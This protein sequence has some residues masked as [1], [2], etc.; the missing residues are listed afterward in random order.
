MELDSPHETY[1]LVA[2]TVDA[3]EW[4]RLLSRVTGLPD[5]TRIKSAKVAM[6]AAW[7][8]ETAAKL[9]GKKAMFNRN[10]VRHVIQRQRYDCS[11]ATEELGITY[12]SIEETLR[13]TVRWY[14]DN[15][16]VTHEKNLMIARRTLAKAL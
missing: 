6:P 15:N 1:L 13:D 2:E 12:R 7:L 14:V 16:W 11:R 4:S 8:F 10:A 5:D 9:Q 3:V